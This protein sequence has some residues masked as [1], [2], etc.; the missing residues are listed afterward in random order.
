MP[1][2]Q[3]FWVRLYPPA[4][5]VNYCRAVKDNKNIWG[6]CLFYSGWP[7]VCKWLPKEKKKVAG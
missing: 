2:W 1:A 3:Q 5:R 4:L 6:D 7:E